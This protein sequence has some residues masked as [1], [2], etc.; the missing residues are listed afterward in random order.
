M[1]FLSTSP[2]H[3]LDKRS[4]PFRLNVWTVVVP[5][6]LVALAS[7][8]VFGLSSLLPQFTNKPEG[9]GAQAKAPVVDQTIE[10]QALK[11]SMARVRLAGLL[12]SKDHEQ[13]S[14]PSVAALI[15]AYL[16]AIPAIP[17][18]IT[19]K[20]PATAWSFKG[21]TVQVSG[22]KEHAC[23]L[24]NGGVLYAMERPGAQFYCYGTKDGY[25]AVFQQD[26]AT[27][28][29]RG[30]RLVTATFSIESLNGATAVNL[31]LAGEQES[32][33]RACPSGAHIAPHAAQRSSWLAHPLNSAGKYVETFCIP[34]VEG[35]LNSF[36]SGDTAA[37]GISSLSKTINSSGEDWTL[38]VA[39]Y[40]IPGCLTSPEKVSVVYAAGVTKGKA[41]TAH[42]PKGCLPELKHPL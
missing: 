37:K 9:R 34:A 29:T 1:R 10:I 7:L 31:Q 23:S 14:P 24:I 36:K 41:N 17:G 5:T 35:S 33:V 21:D 4:N 20:S 30:Y 27:A 38:F 40:A 8:I 12:Y 18:F 19:E 3:L 15:G 26:G 2:V 28:T 6:V 32:F 39:G 16:K 13:A 22:V 42:L 11:D 25:T